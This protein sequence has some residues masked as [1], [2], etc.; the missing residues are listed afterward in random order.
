[1]NQVQT[2][3]FGLTTTIAMIV[4]IVIGSGIFFKTD[5]ILM[6]TNGSVWLGCLAWLFGAVGIIFGGLSVSVLAEKSDE[7]GGI[8][9]Y[10]ELVGN[11]T[12]GFLTGWFLMIIYYPAL[13]AIIAWVA[14]LYSC[15][16]FGFEPMGNIHWLITVAYMA[17]VAAM[18]AYATKLAGYFQSTTMF[19]KLIPLIL[20]ALIGLLFG[21]PAAMFGETPAFLTLF[22]TSSSAIVSVAFA[23]DGWLVAP[24]ICHEVKNAKRNIPL[25]LVFAP[26]FIMLVYLAY[27]I[28]MSAMLGPARIMELGDAHIY[29]VANMIFG[30]IGA[31]LIL[32]FVVISVLGTVNGLFLGLARIPYALALRKDLPGYKK[33]SEVH[34]SYDMP[35]RSCLIALIISLCWLIIHYLTTQ[36]SFLAKL[37]ISNLPIVLTYLFYA[38]MYIGI[39]RKT[40]QGFIK[41]KFRGYVCPTLSL[42]GAAIILISGFQDPMVAFYLV[43]SICAIFAGLLIQK[44]SNTIDM[45]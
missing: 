41:S 26:I 45:N 40:K 13:Y 33:I 5:D 36:V 29:E 25:A 8:V 6:Q 23:F 42:I 31:K 27:F 37:D 7:A 30:G 2:K 1:M 4:G 20:I 24:S 17:G 16:L 32:T 15:L 44:K 14:A 19:I 38:F 3:K 28:G 39:I 11:K 10:I 34:P 35:L 21:K 9:T 18:N 22:T 12:A 43:V